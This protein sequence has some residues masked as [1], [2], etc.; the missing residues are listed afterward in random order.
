MVEWRS[1][2]ARGLRAPEGFILPC[3]P[4]L[5]TMV[6]TGAEWVH[7]V[8]WDGYR[9]IV[10]KDVARV[11]VWSRNAKVW[12]QAFPAIVEAVRE[13]PADTFVLDGEAVCLRPDGR[14]DFHALKSPEA[15]KGAR[16]VTFD[17]LGLDGVDLRLLSLDER[18][19]RLD[20]LLGSGTDAIWPSAMLENGPALYREACGL[21]LEGVVS[22][23]RNSR[24]RSGQSDTW[25]KTLCPAYSRGS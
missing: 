18:R 19:K 21:G 25:R 17:L 8:K 7:E 3:Q 20:Q 22:K 23:R 16:L 11:Q 9:M 2:P 15:C 1:R 12:T 14:P 4:V 24:Y 13:L 6:P 5:S 10:R